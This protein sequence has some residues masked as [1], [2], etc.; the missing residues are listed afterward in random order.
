MSLEYAVPDV[1]NG[2][3]VPSMSTARLRGRSAA[4]PAAL[5]ANPRAARAAA[6]AVVDSI[7]W[8]GCGRVERGKAGCAVRENEGSTA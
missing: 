7:F 6:P 1:M 3:R 5:V 2:M 8:V 4:A